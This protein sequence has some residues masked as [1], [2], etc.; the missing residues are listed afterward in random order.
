[1]KISVKRKQEKGS[2]FFDLRRDSQS[3]RLDLAGYWSYPS[4]VR[5]NGDEGRYSCSWLYLILPVVPMPKKKR[6]A[7]FRPKVAL[8]TKANSK[9]VVRYDNFRLGHDP[10]PTENWNEPIA[11]YP[12]K[13]VK[14]LTRAQ[15]DK[16]EE[17]LL[18]LCVEES[19][20]FA[21]KGILSEDFR[22]AWLGL[23]HPVFLPYIRL[24]APEFFKG[25]GMEN[26]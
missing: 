18:D 15:L 17:E 7:I 4:F 24:L 11:M 3:S 1:M 19:S 14:D 2:S 23:I 5:Q 13:S 16:K 12:H 10:F 8:L 6:T 26:T 20:L 21:E 22:K 25:L 9:T